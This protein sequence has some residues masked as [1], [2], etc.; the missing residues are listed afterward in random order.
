M[1]DIL[2][3]AQKLIY[4]DAFT[5]NQLVLTTG[6]SDNVTGF[7]NLVSGDQ[8]LKHNGLERNWGRFFPEMD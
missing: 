5:A 1:I 2:I 6:V 7:E 4:P 8:E 3:L